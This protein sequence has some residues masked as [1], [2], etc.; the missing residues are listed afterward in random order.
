MDEVVLIPLTSLRFIRGAVKQSSAHQ[1]HLR[2]CS[3]YLLSTQ[4]SNYQVFCFDL[5][6]VT[7]YPDFFIFYFFPSLTRLQILHYISTVHITICRKALPSLP[8]S[9]KKKVQLIGRS[10]AELRITHN[11]MYIGTSLKATASQQGHL[12]PLA[13]QWKAI[14]F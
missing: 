11:T 6:K 3:L 9:K 1:A 13:E 2:R 10:S 4:K 8:F 14:F 12:V 7:E 5:E